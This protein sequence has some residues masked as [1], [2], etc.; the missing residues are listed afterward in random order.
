MKNDLIYLY[1]DFQFLVVF[2]FWSIGIFAFWLLIL[3]KM[4]KAKRERKPDRCRSSSWYMQ[5]TFWPRAQEL[6]VNRFWGDFLHHRI[7]SWNM[8]INPKFYQ[9]FNRI[10]KTLVIHFLK[11]DIV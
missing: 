6:S 3:K 2:N 10:I 5:Y 4:L 8:K 7:N 9:K 11:F 1:F